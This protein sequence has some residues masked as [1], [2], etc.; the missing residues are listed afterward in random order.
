MSRVN[1]VKINK[2][3]NR[4][5]MISKCSA[6]LLF[7]GVLLY[8]YFVNSSVFLI[9]ERGDLD[10][11]ISDIGVKV[12]LL[13][14]DCVKERGGITLERARSLGFTEDFSRIDFANADAGS[15]SGRFSYLGNEI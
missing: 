10:K 4:S 9:K 15:V 13:E 3:P 14:S 6:F 1:I 8:F 7:I 12:S 11:K 5:E 2:I